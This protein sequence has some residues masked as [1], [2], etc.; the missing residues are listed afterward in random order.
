MKNALRLAFVA[1]EIADE[2]V[3]SAN[4]LNFYTI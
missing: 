3:E 1:E 4:T 2:L